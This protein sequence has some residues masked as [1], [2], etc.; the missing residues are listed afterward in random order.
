MSNGT[1][2]R[3]GMAGTEMTGAEMVV[4]ALKDNG[5]KHVF[6]YPGGAV[7]PIYDELFQQDDVQHILVR[8]EQGAG[9]AA[10]GYARS[11]GKAGVMLVTS[12]PGATN[13]VTA[14][15]DALMDSIPLVCLTG[16]V[17]TTLIG[18]DAFQECDTVGIT[19]P[20]TKHNWL[21]KDVNELASI[22]HEA[23]H[24]AT[25]GRPGPV[26][27]D[28]PKDVQFAKGT[29][30]PPQTAPRTSYQPK[31]QGDLDKVRA[32][33]ELMAGARQPIIYTGGGVINSG[34]E[35]SHLLRELVELTGFP[36][37]S[38]LMGLGAY[39]A[40]GKNWLGML[41]MHGSY[42]ANMAMHD[43]DVM[44][45]IG[46]RFDDRI[47]GRLDAF[48]PNSKKIH[49]DIDPSSINKNV[50]VDIGI[51]GDC[52]RVLE[53]MVRLWRATV[54]ADKK[55]LRPWWEQ[56]AR[57]RARDSFAYKPNP[58]VIMPQYAIQ[59]LFA[60]TRD[61][62]TYITTEVGQHQM[63]AAQHFHFDK[64]NRWMTSGGLGTMG[65]GLPAALGVQ[66][67]HPDAL[68]IDIAGDA[69]VQMTIQEMSAAV[70]YEA[71]IKIF[72][73]NNQYM[74]M[75]RQWQQLLHGNRL[76]HSYT[77]AMP[78]FV[79]LAEAYGGHGIR[80]EKPDELDDAIR[81]MISVRKP[82]LFDCRV[83]NLANCFPMIPSGKAHNEMLLPD[84]ATDE[85]VA[86]AI[87]AKGRELV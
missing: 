78:D 58:D 30:V 28:I 34:P 12:G 24:V 63:W 17:P 59:R 43:C 86:N 41:G 31:V 21:V 19:R 5:V 85:A 44:L 70:Q 64:P 57:W 9:H 65:Y 81:E 87:D 79:K 2:E 52:G 53:D 45:C 20:C 46:A 84:E 18:S 49:I 61:H 13:A 67:A 1:S 55:A 51:A 68:V 71:P 69:S 37:T 66:V 48:S 16:Q 8:H 60:L 54:K 27:V 73:L 56:I 82:V 29:Y 74:G 7:L 23:F 62:D 35:A 38:T 47:T 33:I 36:I 11:T 75:V 32:A 26:V 50:R 83:A 4:Q 77:E 40:S 15:Q 22:I 39:P 80:C 72:I 10:E 25:T 6:G 76:S 3:H 14:L 42:E